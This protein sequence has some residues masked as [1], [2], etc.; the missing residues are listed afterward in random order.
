MSE[1]LLPA[2]FS[3]AKQARIVF[4]GT[5]DF[6]LPS[7]ERLCERGW[8]VLALITQPDRPQGRKQVIIP[9]PIRVSA[10]NRGIPVL[11]PENLNSDEG[12]AL[13][14]QYHPDI[15]VTVAYGQILKPHILK[16]AAFG[17]VNLHGSLLPKYRGAAPVARC[18]Q[19]GDRETG[20]TVIQMSPHVD[21]GCILSK[22]ATPIGEDETAA[23][24]ESR[25]SELGS[26]LLESTLSDFLEGRIQ[27]L[28][29]NSLLATRAPK[30]SKEEALIDWSQSAFMTDRFIRAMNPWPIART[31]F[32][33]SENVQAL[34]VLIHESLLDQSESSCEASLDGQV[35]GLNRDSIQVCCGDGKAILIKKVQTEGRKPL[36][37]GDWARGVRLKLGDRFLSPE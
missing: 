3:D 17:G 33:G 10:E 6:A 13:L 32:Q 37:A 12:L 11:Q 30:L 28:T 15:L 36:P 29:Q 21:A 22:L 34:N 23:S 2:P 18:L 8:N 25:L 31:R 1:N 14:S 16:L 5:K 35:T 9:S 19:A 24:L 27:P 4:L 26:P 7:F 20:V